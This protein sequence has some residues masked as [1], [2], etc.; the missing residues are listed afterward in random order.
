MSKEH[1]ESPEGNE[2]LREQAQ[3]LTHYLE[4][5]LFNSPP[6]QKEGKM[7]G[8]TKD[9]TH[10]KAIIGMEKKQ[11]KNRVIVFYNVNASLISK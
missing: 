9:I 4:F 11:C 6:C 1:W 3:T 5:Q 10:I 8:L 2:I 7:L